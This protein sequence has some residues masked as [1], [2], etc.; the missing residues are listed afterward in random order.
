MKSEEQ[1]YR[2]LMRVNRIQRVVYSIGILAL[3]VMAYMSIQKGE[4]ILSAVYALLAIW[5]AVNLWLTFT[6]VEHAKEIRRQ[7]T[8]EEDD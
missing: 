6:D 2:Y 8:K 1:F 4:A 7:L 3:L 5:G